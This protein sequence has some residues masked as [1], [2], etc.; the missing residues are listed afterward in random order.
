MLKPE[1]VKT[2]RARWMPGCFRSFNYLAKRRVG[3]IPPDPECNETSRLLP[4]ARRARLS[5]RARGSVIQ[6]CPQTNF[7]L[8]SAPPR[9]WRFCA[10]RQRFVHLSPN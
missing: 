9:T 8:A 7:P 3:E 6:Y 10:A 5:Q 4:T 2:E 1:S